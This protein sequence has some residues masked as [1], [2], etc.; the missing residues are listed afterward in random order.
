MYLLLKLNA[1]ESTLSY[2]N[3]YVIKVKLFQFECNFLYYLHNSLDSFVDRNLTSMPIEKHKS[4]NSQ[5]I[6]IFIVSENNRNNFHS[7]GIKLLFLSIVCN[8]FGK[9]PRCKN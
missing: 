2:F 3:S 5:R 4:E 7:L 8:K 6:E 1:F 9:I